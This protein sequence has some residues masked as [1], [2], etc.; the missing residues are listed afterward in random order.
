MKPILLGLP[1]GR[2]REGVQKLMA[3]AGCPVQTTSR[4]YRASVQ[5]SGFEAKI[6]KP[7]GIVEMLQAG[8]RDVG[9]AG[10]DWVKE[11]N[12]DLVELLDTEMDK[13]RIVAAAPESLLENG[14][15]PK[16]PLIVASEYSRITKSW[17][18]NKG[19]QV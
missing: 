1:K 16:R 13:V 8:R 12:V 6:L 7:Q 17:I 15:L 9:F 18:E 19:H 2:M 4:D 3:D 11:L 5:L 10:A 14:Q